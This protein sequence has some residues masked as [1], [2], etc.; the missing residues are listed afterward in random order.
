MVRLKI[1]TVFLLI[2]VIHCYT[3]IIFK[4]TSCG[5]SLTI[6]KHW[7]IEKG[8]SSAVCVF[9][10]K[11]PAWDTIV[12]NTTHHTRTCSISIQMVDGSIEKNGNI[13]ACFQED[14][15]WW[16]GGMRGARD[17]AKFIRNSFWDAVIGKS[18]VSIDNKNNVGGSGTGFVLVAL[19][20][21]R[22]GRLVNLFSD[23]HFTDE[24]TFEKIVN[25][26]R[27]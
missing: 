14:S 2:P 15:T 5:L 26:I 27:F 13:Y 1:L 25:S 6:P 11:Y 7:T 4:D 23:Y 21:N 22:N 8:K 10:M 16:I 12:S 24:V 20:D 3:Q 19:L 17:K 9:Q 18:E